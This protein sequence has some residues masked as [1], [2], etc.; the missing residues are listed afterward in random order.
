MKIILH[1]F[2]VPL[3]LLV[4]IILGSIHDSCGAITHPLQTDGDATRNGRL[5]DAI[6]QGGLWR[7]C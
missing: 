2:T 3:L 1:R 5:P 7:I 4:G 6:T